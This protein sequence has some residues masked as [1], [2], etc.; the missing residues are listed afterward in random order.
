MWSTLEWEGSSSLIPSSS[1]KNGLVSETGRGAPLLHGSE[2][3]YTGSAS[4]CVP[5]SSFF[6]ARAHR[7]DQESAAADSSVFSLSILGA[8]SRPSCT[9]GRMS[10]SAGGEPKPGKVM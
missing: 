8:V 2:R 10:L 9:S 7:L 3:T 1:E 6:G 5:D 4:K